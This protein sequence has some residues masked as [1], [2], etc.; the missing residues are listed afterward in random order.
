MSGETHETKR[1]S[2]SVDPELYPRAKM[3]RLH[4]SGV[5]ERALRVYLDRLDNSG[6]QAGAILDT[7]GDEASAGR[8][9]PEVVIDIEHVFRQ[10]KCR[11]I[12][13]SNYFSSVE[14]E[15][16]DDWL[17]SFSFTWNQLT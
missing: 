3:L 5:S 1:I 15:I 16:A 8:N 13:L 7:N 4:G 11:P 2:S 17:R 14:T 6:G 10:I 9:Q 12:C